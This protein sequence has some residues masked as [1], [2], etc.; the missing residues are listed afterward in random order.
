MAYDYGLEGKNVT[1]VEA[2][3]ALMDNDP[4]GVPYWT[5]DLLCELLERTKCKICTGCRLEEINDE[6]A[7]ISRKDGSK[8]QLAADDVIMAIGFRKRA[9]MYESLMG[10]GKEIYEITVGNGI[11]NIQTQVSSA[12]EIARKL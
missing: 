1:I 2:L 12:F 10:C 6:G 5:K 11:G 7:V 9:S 3:D 8:E 4:A